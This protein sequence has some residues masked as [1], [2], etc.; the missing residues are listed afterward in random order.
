MNMKLILHSTI[1]TNPMRYLELIVLN[2][3]LILGFLDIGRLYQFQTQTIVLKG[4]AWELCA[5]F[6]TSPAEKRQR[7]G[8]FI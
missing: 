8:S 1:A 5:F 7:R 6:L 2:A 3:V 4:P